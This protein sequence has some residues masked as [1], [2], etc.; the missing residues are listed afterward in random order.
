MFL[1]RPKS[2]SVDD[3]VCVVTEL[4]LQRGYKASL[5]EVAEVLNLSRSSIY[6]TWSNKDRLFVAVLRRYG[7]SRAPGLSEVRT[8]AA[9]RAALV[10]LFELATVVECEPCLIINTLVEIKPGNRDPEI[11]R[12]IE[13]AVLELEESLAD[14]VRRGQAAAEIGPDVDPGRAGHVLLALY[15]GLYV[16]IRTGTAGKPV[17]RA[18]VRQVE[19][20]LPAPARH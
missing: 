12:L 10:R 19:A 1:R 20:M 6:L 15:L 3:A 11:G 4:F 17:L 16:L 9:P 8:A 14:A 2:F 7:L 5:R 18:V 13:A